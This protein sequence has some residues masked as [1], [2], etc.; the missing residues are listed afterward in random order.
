VRAQQARLKVF[1]QVT[2]GQQRVRLGSVEPQP[3]QL[4]LA[5]AGFGLA[6]AVTAECPVPD[7][8]GVQADPH[9]LQIAL[10]G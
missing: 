2:H 7:D 9:V 3:R 5:R 6:E 1:Q 4:V 8:G 10:D